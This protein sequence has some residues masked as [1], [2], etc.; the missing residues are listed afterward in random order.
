MHSM[1]LQLP[2]IRLEDLA[3]ETRDWLLAAAAAEGVDPVALLR[4]TLDAA[5]TRDG[6]HPA[7]ASDKPAA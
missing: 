6:F 1:A 7:P 5:A 3:P 2:P 4:R